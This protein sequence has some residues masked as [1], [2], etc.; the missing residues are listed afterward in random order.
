MTQVNDVFE[1]TL[2]TVKQ[3]WADGK[4]TPKDYVYLLM[5]AHIDS[6]SGFAIKNVEAF[7]QEWNLTESQFEEGTAALVR[8][9]IVEETSVSLSE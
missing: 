8:E 4:Y 5:L 6:V 9:G 2:V 1:K 3:A 7:C